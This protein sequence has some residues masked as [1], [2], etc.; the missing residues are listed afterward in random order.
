M[1][2]TAFPSRSG[3]PLPRSEL[4]SVSTQGCASD[5]NAVDATTELAGSV[6]RAEIDLVLHHFGERIYEIFINSK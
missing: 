2:R 6:S 1:A 4:P 5:T 3:S